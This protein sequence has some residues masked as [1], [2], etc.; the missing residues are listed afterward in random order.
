MG[1]TEGLVSVEL[2]E[3]DISQAGKT[4]SGQ[5]VGVVDREDPELGSGLREEK[6]DDAVEVAKTFSGQAV[7]VD[8]APG[9][10]C[11]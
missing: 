3:R 6:D 1:A 9:P 5:V 2:G 10:F 7:R 11:R 8:L 4:V